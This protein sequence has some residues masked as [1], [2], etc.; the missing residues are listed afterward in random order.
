MK[1]LLRIFRRGLQ[2]QGK[3][4][5]NI[6]IPQGMQLVQDDNLFFYHT[7]YSKELIKAKLQRNLF[8]PKRKSR[9]TGCILHCCMRHIFMNKET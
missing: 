8:C 3:I 1:L 2:Y 5:E 7:G 9:E 4:H 6:V